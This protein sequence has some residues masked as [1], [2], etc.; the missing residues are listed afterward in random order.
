L[1]RKCNSKEAVQE[2]PSYGPQKHIITIKG[3]VKKASDNF[4]AVY[5]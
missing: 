1:A 3:L 2:R 5:V 4:P